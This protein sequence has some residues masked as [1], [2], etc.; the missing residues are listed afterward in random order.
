MSIIDRL[1]QRIDLPYV[2]AV[3]GTVMAIGGTVA[4][5]AEASDQVGIRQQVTEQQ[6]VLPYEG[7]K[8]VTN[9]DLL[10]ASEALELQIADLVTESGEVG[11]N[12]PAGAV[13]IAGLG[14]FAAG[15]YNG[16][17]NL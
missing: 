4:V 7:P 2:A 10:A 17:K 16:T 3:T 5:L 6:A 13:A 15:V 11:S 12:I 14:I 8:I 9:A 1:K